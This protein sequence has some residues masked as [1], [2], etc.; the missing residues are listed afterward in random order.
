[1]SDFEFVPIDGCLLPIDIDVHVI[2]ARYSAAGALIDDAHE[3]H[4]VRFL[5]I[6]RSDEP[7]CVSDESHHVAWFTPAEI[8]R[9]TTEESVLRMLRKTLTLLG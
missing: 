3:H 9:L 8:E 2:P 6:A 7:V 4:D 5:F 1:M